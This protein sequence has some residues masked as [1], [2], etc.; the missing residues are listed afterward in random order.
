[1]RIL[2]LL[3][4]Y[5]ELFGKAT[6]N[7]EGKNGLGILSA[8]PIEGKQLLKLPLPDTTP[9]RVLL[10]ALVALPNNRYMRFCNTQ[11]DDRSPLHRGL[12]AAVVNEVLQYSIQPVI[13]AGDMNVQPNDH[14]LEALTKYWIDAGAN[15]QEGTFPLTGKR[16]DY[17]WTLK[18]SAFKWLD[19][20]VLN[21][22][23]TAE[24]QPVLVNYV[25][26]NKKL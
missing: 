15:S 5:N 22:P 8:H 18:G 10:C 17:V 14:T 1:M 23:N 26:E 2:S 7:Q 13:L 24:H 4:G 12:Q 25:L 16:I 3:T 6:D 21:E 19:Y 20:K 9:P 11:L